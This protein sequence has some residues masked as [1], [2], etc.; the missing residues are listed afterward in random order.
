MM[1]ETL[2][3]LKVAA[4]EQR[5]ALMIKLANRTF[6][7]NPG[8]IDRGVSWLLGKMLGEPE[9]LSEEFSHDTPT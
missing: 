2:G 4:T 5:G 6:R 9:P 7:S 1:S 8:R 3:R